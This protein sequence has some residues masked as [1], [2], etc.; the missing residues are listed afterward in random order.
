MKL[1]K[2]FPK[3]AYHLTKVFLSVMKLNQLLHSK[4]EYSIIDS[5]S[6]I[7]KDGYKYPMV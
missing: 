6:S 3:Y 5:K 4:K 1:S 2:R 7:L